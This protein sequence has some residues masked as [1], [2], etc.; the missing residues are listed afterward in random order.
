MKPGA[1][2]VVDLLQGKAIA[3]APPYHV[4]NAD[5]PPRSSNESGRGI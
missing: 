1:L 4:R 2:S 3:V 5:S